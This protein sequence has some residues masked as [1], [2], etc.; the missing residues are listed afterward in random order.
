MSFVSSL[1][2]SLPAR[3]L[4]RAVAKYPF[5]RGKTRLR[6]MSRSWLVGQLQFGSWVRVSGVV[7][8]EWEYLLGHVKESATTEFLSS[9]IKR[10]MTFVDVGA[11]VGYFTL[12][13]ASL[14]ARVVAYEPTPAVY[15]RLRE[16]VELNGLQN[17]TLMNAA[18]AEK[19]GS[20]TFHQSPDDPEANSIFGEGEC[21]QVEAVALDEELSR[22][23]IHQVDLLK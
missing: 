21:I 4:S 18:V 1:S 9:F 8:A 5:E 15:S 22:R 13:A 23:G 7:D 17:V 16:N 20:L 3:V 10:G 6:E 2:P 14:E 12:L 11:N 19:A